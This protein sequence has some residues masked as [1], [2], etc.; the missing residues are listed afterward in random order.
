MRTRILLESKATPGAR[1]VERTVATRPA[2]A[3]AVEALLARMRPGERLAMTV[4][5]EAR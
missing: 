3:R 4:V 1:R 5:S 2:A